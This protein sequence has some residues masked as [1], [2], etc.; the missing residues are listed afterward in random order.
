VVLLCAES[1]DHDGNLY[2]GPNTE[3]TPDDRRAAAFHDAV[4]IVQANDI[5]DTANLPRVDIPGS[6]VDF[7]VQA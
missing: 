7:I 5:V 3:D 2:T 6:W 1:A 4:V